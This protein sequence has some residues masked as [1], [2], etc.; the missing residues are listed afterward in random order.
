MRLYYPFVVLMHIQYK[1][2]TTFDKSTLVYFEAMKSCM[3][4][5]QY[6]GQ[7]EAECDEWIERQPD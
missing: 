6:K 5:E 4:V 3:Y 2:L 1:T 7:T